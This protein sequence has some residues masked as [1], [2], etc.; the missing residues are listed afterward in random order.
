MSYMNQKIEI[1]QGPPVQGID[2]FDR[3]EIVDDIWSALHK[4]SVLLT[5]PRRFGKTSVMMELRN[6]P[7][8]DIAV[9]YFDIE[10]LESP[11]EFILE[12]MNE[13]KNND[14]IWGKIKTGIKSL[15][16]S[17]GDNIEEFEVATVRMKLRESDD[18][19]WKD[20]GD[21]LIDLMIKEKGRL[22]LVLDEF[23]E[24]MKCMI[25]NDE[26]EAR[27]FLNWFR[28]I[29]QNKLEDVRFIIGGSICLENILNKINCIDKINDVKILRIEPFSKDIA[30]KFITALFESKDMEIDCRIIETIK[31]CIGEP[32]PF[33]I[34]VMIDTI[35]KESRKEK[36]EIDPSFVR[37]VYQKK[38]LGSDYKTYF[39]HYYRRLK[40][41]Y[42]GASDQHEIMD[43]AKNILTEIS[44]QGEVT[45]NHLYQLYIDEMG[46]SEAEDGFGELMA[47]L[48]Q[49]FYLNYDEKE[50]TH[51]FFSKILKDWWYRHFG[52]LRNR[53]VVA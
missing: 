14:H 48:E 30:T 23:P 12:L 20:L 18:L 44:V 32:I 34:Q 49:E 31:E 36:R 46:P 42:V 4:S 51:S 24:M 8:D 16:N 15:F 50:N 9:F 38:L 6:N 33:F 21:R 11:E 25:E 35:I 47:L 39:D 1:T 19:N 40:E 28:H 53:K 43:V 37:E 3:E 45:R 17:I 29:R 41:Y 10:H 22:V 52:S 2:F 26:K 27:T 5:A 7:K 13:I